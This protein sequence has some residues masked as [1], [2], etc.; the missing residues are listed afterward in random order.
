MAFNDRPMEENRPGA[1]TASKDSAVDGIIQSP[2][3]NREGEPRQHSVR[4]VDQ[5]REIVKSLIAANRTRQ[6]INS[7]ITAKYN[8]ERPYDQKRLETEGLGWKQNFT[9][10]PLPQ[11][12]EKVYPRFVQVVEALKYFTNSRLSDKWENA[13]E[14]TEK[15]RKIITDVI[16]ERKGWKTLLEDISFENALFGHNVVARLDEFSWFPKAFKQDECFL[17]DGT[18]QL[19]TFA[20]VLV[21][22]EMML[23]HELYALVKDRETA[24]TVGWKIEATIKQINLA[25]P[26]Q[27]RDQLNVGGTQESWYQNAERE[28]NVGASYMSGASVV[29]VYSLLAREVTGEVSHY[30]L[31][32]DSLELIYEKDNRFCCMDACAAFF[33][34]QRGNG[35]MHGSKGIGRDIYELSGM[36]DRLRNDIVDRSVLSGKTVVQGDIKRIHTFKMS[37]VGAMLILPIGWQ[38][39]EN[40]V[41]GNVE[42]LLK[43]DAYFQML[44][45]QL[46]GNT[47]PPRPEGEAF[48][49]PA[50]WQLLAAREEEGKDTKLARFME[51]FVCLIGMM[52]KNILDPDTAEEDAKDVQKKLKEFLTKEELKEL[53]ESPVAGTIRDLTPLERQLIVAIAAEKKGNP[54][55]NQRALEVEDL[56]SR[57]GTDFALRVLLPVNDPTE[58][59]EQQRLQQIELGLLSQGQPVPVSPRDNHLIHLE[60]LAPVS[61]QT[62]QAIMEGQSDTAALEAILSHLTEHYNAAI[63]MGAPKAQLKPY[64]DL[65]KNTGKVLAE[66]KQVDAQAQELSAESQAHDTEEL[67]PQPV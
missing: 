12:I 39:L 9:T 18:K 56:T 57:I 32:G 33:S 67:P 63:A 55:Y 40:K 24:K 19:P 54:L 64:A 26:S 53:R 46:I 42:P 16:R 17:S 6:V 3:L 23:P 1:A 5:A 7:R 15:F 10:K 49:S 21:L 66:L 14:K 47:S 61:E 58:Q 27:I 20:Q 60:I 28:L 4:D 44:V 59:A 25:S 48:R 13:T 38:V 37:V 34:Y 30:R 35:T 8:A 43:L 45:D 50:A 41:D 11:I 52:Q 2:D 31:A 36:L 51:Q 22:R 62:A 29:T 65:V